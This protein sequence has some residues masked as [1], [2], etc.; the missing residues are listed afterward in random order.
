MRRKPSKTAKTG[1]SQIPEAARS[2]QKAISTLAKL[3][4][5]EGLKAR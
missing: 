2:G 4:T 5:L 3:G 1:H